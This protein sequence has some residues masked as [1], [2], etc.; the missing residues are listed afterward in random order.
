MDRTADAS[1]ASRSPPR[2][3]R[4]ATPDGI[5][6]ARAR[7][8]VVAALAAAA[9]AAGCAG[10]GRDAPVVAPTG[11]IYARG[12]PPEDTRYSQTAALYL[13]R[14]RPERALELAREGISAAPENPIHHYF[15][16]IALVRLDRY[17]EADSMLSRAEEIHPAYELEVEPVRESAWAD[18][19]NQGIDA[20][21]AGD[22]ER[23]IEAWRRATAIYDLRPRAHRSLAN[24]LVGEGRRGDAVEVLREALSGLERRPATRVLDPDD[25]RER[26]EAR[27]SIERDLARLLLREERF[28]E[29]EPLLRRRLADDP[30]DVRLRKDLA[31]ALD[32][33][34]RDEEADR[35]YATL[36]SEA[37]LA[38][39]DLLD[40]GVTLFR[41]GSYG[42]AAEAFAR[43]TD[44]QPGSR[45][46]WYNYAN[47]LFAAEE[48][49]ELSAAGDRLLEVDPLGENA[50]L[51][52]ARAHLQAGREDSAR[53][54]ADRVERAPVHVERLEM[55]RAGPGT[56]V[57]GRVVGNE[58]E[59]GRPIR[60]RF[61]FYAGGS[62]LGAETVTVEAPSPG[63]SS[64]IRVSIPE[65]ADAYRYEVADRDSSPARSTTS[66]TSARR[67]RASNTR[68]SEIVYRR[69][70]IRRAPPSGSVR[71]A[72]WPYSTFRSSRGLW[73]STRKSAS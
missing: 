66:R 37:D 49:S 10:A 59:P 64:S 70:W 19:F 8:G 36:V 27:A 1:A 5:V 50:W 53:T 29:A 61:V 48:W 26:R 52:V 34:G 71:S 18:A 63:E 25:V 21:A 7:A 57:R 55:Q 17:A 51:I 39:P 58:A 41:S 54:L 15:A 2:S 9:V 20:R 4:G 56:S 6:P 72:P 22:V 42:R 23:A 69:P 62:V 11:K 13:R 3:R 32:R 38:P 68:P 40:L 35:L 65:R 45:D 14:D 33:M 44:R 73:S 47:A 24:A 16:G 60:L 28:A 67:D 12:T 43:L 46:A 30:G 31:R